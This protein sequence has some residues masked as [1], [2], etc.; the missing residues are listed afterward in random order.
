MSP[1]M[2][3]NR[4]QPHFARFHHRLL[5]THSPFMQNPRKLHDQ[6][7]LDTTIP[8]IMITPMSD[9]MFNVVC[10][11]NRNATTPAIPG[12]I[13]VRM[14]NGSINERNC[15]IRIRYNQNQPTASA[16]FQPEKRFIH[17]HRRAL[18]SYAGVLW[19]AQPA[20]QF[21]C[22]RVD[23]AQI[24]CLRHHENIDHASQLVVIH[25]RWRV[26]SARSWPTD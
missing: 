11:M 7:L 12:G 26:S 6:D 15:A 24:L 10:V 18:H 3:S 1:A 20:H 22:L 14:M 21:A 17:P 9:M 23:L 25:F 8:V 19:E 5:Q 4:P 13:A 16:R 2:S